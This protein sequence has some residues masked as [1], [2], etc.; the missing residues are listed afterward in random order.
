MLYLK[1]NLHL[2]TITFCPPTPRFYGRYGGDDNFALHME[3]LKEIVID[4][5]VLL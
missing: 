3:M 4:E 5:L 2:N 1:G